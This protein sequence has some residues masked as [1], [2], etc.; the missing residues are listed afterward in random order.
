[1]DDKERFGAIKVEQPYKSE[2]KIHA[3]IVAEYKKIAISYP[4]TERNVVHNISFS[5][6]RGS[7]VT[8]FGRSGCGKSTL[9]NVAAGLLNP[10]EGEFLFEQ[11][12]LHGVNTRISYMT[13]KN[14][15]LPWRTVKANIELPLKLQKI[16]KDTIKQKVT[17]VL[18][19]T[20]L[21][22]AGN[23]FPNQLSGGMKQRCLLARSLVT[24]P[25]VLLMDEPFSGIDADLREH[26]HGTLRS[27]VEKLKLTVLFVTHDVAEAALLSDAVVILG[28]PPGQA[29]YYAEQIDIPFGGERDLDHIRNSESFG[30]MQ[31]H[32]RHALTRASSEQGDE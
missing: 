20:Q 29:T 30:Q 26:L 6:K 14:T 5:V 32:L 18:E 9:L 22:D 19:L 27:A 23:R 15:L 25:S 7:F 2:P 17:Q 8:L 3:D 11:Q 31:L 21:S 16:S 12:Q 28:T 4:G 1:M 13:Q 10:T 24:D